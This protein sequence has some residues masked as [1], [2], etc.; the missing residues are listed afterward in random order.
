MAIISIDDSGPQLIHP[1]T[2][3]AA[4]IGNRDLANTILWA[5][6][7]GSV[8][9]PI[10]GSAGLS[11]PTAEA[12]LL[13]PLEYVTINGDEEV[14][15][16]VYIP[17]GSPPDGSQVSV[18]VQEG[19]TSWTPSATLIADAIAESGLALAIAQSVAGSGISLLGSPV[20]LYAIQSS[21]GSGVPGRLGATLDAASY[22]TTTDFQAFPIFD[23]FVGRPY[24]TVTRKYYNE[25]ITHN[26]V[27]NP[28]MAQDGQSIPSWAAAG[29]KVCVTLKPWRDSTQNYSGT[30]PGQGT[31]TYAQ[32]KANLA[33]AISYL[34][35][36]ATQGLE[37][38]LWHEPNS[39]GNSGPFPSLTGQANGAAYQAY[40][41]FYASAF[42]T[43][44]Y[45]GQVGYV[46]L[47][48]SPNN[49]LDYLPT[50]AV[51]N[52]ITPDL[53]IGFFNGQHAAQIPGALNSLSNYAA[54]HSMRYGYWEIGLSG[55]ATPPTTS[56][57]VTL[58]TTWYLNVMAGRLQS[59]FTNADIIWFDVPPPGG[60]SGQNNINATTAPQI[61]AVLQSMFDTLTNVPASGLVVASGTLAI[62]TPLKASP[63]AGYATA[64]GISYD[65]TVTL[66]SLAAGNTQPFCVLSLLWYN[67]DSPTAPVVDRQSWIAPIGANGTAGTLIVG[68]GPQRGQFLKATVFNED[69]VSCTVTFQLNS[70]SRS[71]TRDSWKWDVASS[72][73]VPQPA[74]TVG[75]GN[76]WQ[77]AGGGNYG[78]SLGSVSSMSVPAGNT[79]Y[80]IFG[81]FS[82]Q[83]F[84]RIN[85]GSSG[86]MN[87]TFNPYPGGFWGSGALLNENPVVEFLEMMLLPRGPC[88]MAV[89]NTD[90]VAHTVNI[91]II[92]LD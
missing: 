79:A 36:V 20:P 73:A 70:T 2:G 90:T 76:T 87:C 9:N 8:F 19:V 72:V 54:A 46:P 66:T 75:T 62:V 68:K 17:D 43:A 39:A 52:Q 74:N 31:L 58:M 40:I 45:T 88:V 5:T 78:N 1:A 10:A 82:G 13:D 50:N 26:G 35:G 83:V 22:G 63:V 89:N 29:F 55:N 24:N 64:N 30:I 4:L 51:I 28:S 6:D 48:S 92:M 16:I 69:A 60:G 25:G 32:E 80:I 38:T 33:T 84:V 23:G 44:G 85:A 27:I 57:A 34:M 15:G 86:K 77:L 59:G 53:Y 71:V 37:I 65:I 42:A 3:K 12:N 47:M 56:Q 49:V 14:W 7:Q 18:I 11:V 81:V 91:E 41:N 61:I 67:V 21:Q